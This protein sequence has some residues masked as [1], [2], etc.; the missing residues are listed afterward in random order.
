MSSS[1]DRSLTLPAFEQTR[2]DCPEDEAADMRGISHAA[3]RLLRNRAE[4]QK[5]K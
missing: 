5:L 3:R 4:T 2:S 1:T